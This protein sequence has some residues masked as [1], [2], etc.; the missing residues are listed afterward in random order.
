ME[1]LESP[2]DQD[3]Y[4]KNKAVVRAATAA[5]WVSDNGFLG[6]VVTGRIQ[7]NGNV[8]FGVEHQA[9][10]FFEQKV[11]RRGSWVPKLLFVFEMLVE[12]AKFRKKMIQAQAHTWQT[13]VEAEEEDT[14]DA[15]A[16]GNA[17]ADLDKATSLRKA[18]DWWEGKCAYCAGK[19]RVGLDL[20]HALSECKR[21][22]AS[23]WD[24]RFGEIVHAK[25]EKA[26]GEYNYCGV[27]KELCTRWE[28]KD[29]KRFKLVED[30][31]YQYMD[32]LYDTFIGLY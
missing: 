7:S 27:P 3:G 8:D 11:L 23:L 2:P 15:R 26:R 6:N 25:V 1:K 17:L 13:S 20:L 19:D 4:C 10:A 21:G 18:F 12:G 9:R 32:I 22:G 29:G 30:G 16:L 24:S 31:R 14:I 28:Q 5:L